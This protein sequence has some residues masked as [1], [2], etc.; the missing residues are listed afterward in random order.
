MK[1][2]DS[3]VSA[4]GTWD[5]YSITRIPFGQEIC[6]TGIQLIRAFCI[7]ANGGR[8]VRP[9]IVRAIVDHDGRIEELNRP[10][11]PVGYIVKPEIA[12]WLV[13]DALVRVVKEGTGKRAKLNEW[14]V[15]GKTGTANIAKADARG[16]SERHYM[17]SF[18]AG[19]PAE[20]PA[21]VVLVSVRNPKKS[22][23]KGYTGG[24]VASP[25]V[26]RIIERTLTYLGVE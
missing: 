2:C 8:L 4:P 7:L 24:L 17:A 23:G 15:F 12:E 20:D 26:K 21:I 16:Y 1:G 14:Q 25:A 22:L 3:S 18:M 13:K 19:A 9:F 6:V 10:P 11:A 5:G